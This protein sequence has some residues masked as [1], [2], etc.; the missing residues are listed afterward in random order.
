MEKIS[1][2]EMSE[3]GNVSE[4][5][6]GTKNFMNLAIHSGIC[7]VM[8]KVSGFEQLEEEIK[9]TEE[10]EEYN[11]EKVTQ[12]PIMVSYKILKVLSKTK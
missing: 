1:E 3:E 11:V 6:E 4:I 5:S 8:S 2:D 9:K 7:G 10:N 12:A